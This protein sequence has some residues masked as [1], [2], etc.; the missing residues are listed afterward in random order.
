LS[1]LLFNYAFREAQETFLG[2]DMHS[3]YPVLNY[4]DDINLIGNDVRTQK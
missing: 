4:E 1:P 3:T 2:L